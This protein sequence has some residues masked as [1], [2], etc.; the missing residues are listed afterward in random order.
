[1]ESNPKL[2]ELVAEQVIIFFN[3]NL[4]LL[5]H[6][7]LLRLSLLVSEARV[8]HSP[9]FLKNQNCHNNDFLS[10]QHETPI[11]YTVPKC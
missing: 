4:C 2:A 3:M 6:Y 11:S 5:T 9:F 1:M 7:K 10:S 8:C